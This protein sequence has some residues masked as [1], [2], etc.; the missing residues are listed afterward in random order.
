MHAF[1][2][3]RHV[4]H[5]YNRLTTALQIAFNAPLLL[6]GNQDEHLACKKLSDEV[7]A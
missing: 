6:V 2:S 7:L 1:S 3:H 5:H 4:K